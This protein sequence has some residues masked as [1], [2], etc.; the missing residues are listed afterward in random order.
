[1]ARDRIIAELHSVEDAKKVEETVKTGYADTT[2]ENLLHWI[3]VEDDLASNYEMLAAKPENASRRG[4]FE[5]LALESRK[6][7]STLADLQKSFEGLDRARV[8]RINLLGSLG[9]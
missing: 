3:A 9:P 7:V 2:I 1:M 6:N 4:V 5:Q 8:Q